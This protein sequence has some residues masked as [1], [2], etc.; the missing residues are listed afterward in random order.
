MKYQEI[1]NQVS[2]EVGLPYEV[3]KEA[4]ES[5]WRF[6]RGTIQSL[7]LKEDLTE[8]EF[9][10]YRTNFNIPSLGKLHCTYD[11]LSRLKKRYKH[12]LKISNNADSKE[13]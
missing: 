11:R 10:K 9:N 7:P 2:K 3:V 8:D 4:Y 5:F 13:D 1:L 6:I 12:Y